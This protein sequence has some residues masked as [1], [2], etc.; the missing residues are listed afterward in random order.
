VASRDLGVGKVFSVTWSPDDPL[1]LAAAGSQARLQIWDVA[2]NAAARKVFGDKLPQ[3]S[4][5]ERSNG[6]LVGVV[7]DDDDGD[8]SDTD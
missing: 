5:K 6:G 7:N 4:W 1:T 2:S 3:R 8:E